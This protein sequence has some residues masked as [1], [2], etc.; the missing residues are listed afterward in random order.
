VSWSDEGIAELVR[1]C[2][3]DRIATA[4]LFFSDD[5]NLLRGNQ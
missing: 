3:D 1:T 5:V 2:Y 4:Q